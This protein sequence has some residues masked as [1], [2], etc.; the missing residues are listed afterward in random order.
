MSA[1]MRFIR[2]ILI[3]AIVLFGLLTAL[4]FLF[5]SQVEISR[6]VRIRAPLKKAGNTVSD[7]GT[8][9]SWNAFARSSSLSGRRV[10]NPSNGEGAVLSFDQLRIKE[11]KADSTLVLFNWDFTRGKTFAGGYSLIPLGADS[12]TV[13]AY[14]LFHLRWYPWEKMGIF[15]YDRKLGP[16]L[17]ESLSGLKSYLENSP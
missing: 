11:V 7:L 1:F 8:W 15:V 14:F 16:L 2:F 13:Q 5:P 6:T 17:E 10:T 9:N 4:S 12:V 3:G